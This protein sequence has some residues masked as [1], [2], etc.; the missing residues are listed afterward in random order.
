[1]APKSLVH[2]QR[3]P[4]VPPVSVKLIG[5][6]KQAGPEF[7]AIA[8]GL[9]F[10]TAVV[11]ALAV[12]LLLISVTITVKTSPFVTLVALG[13]WS[14]VF[15]IIAPILLDHSQ[16]T[17]L[18]PPDSVKLIGSAEHVAPEFPAITAG[19]LPTE[20]VLVDVAVQLLLISV[21]I[22][23]KISPFVTFVALGFWSV[24]FEIIAP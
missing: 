4:L 14:V 5:F 10:I 18:A 13:F 21:T 9:L 7:P 2:A 20:A 11:V 15:E 22:T 24:V 16:L 3:T 1:V 17:P 23:V 6:P 8:V 12:Q 19:L